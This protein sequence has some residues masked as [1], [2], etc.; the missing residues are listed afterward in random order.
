MSNNKTETQVVEINQQFAT[1][2]AAGLSSFPKRLPAKYFY[3]EKGDAIFQQIMG[4]E[5]Y[6]PTRC[7]YE[8]FER[9]KKQLLELFQNT[10]KPFKLL[11]FGAGDGHKTK[12]LLDLFTTQKAVFQYVPIDISAN[13]LEVL[14]ADLISCF[15]NLDIR[16]FNGD[17]FEALESL[18]G[19]TSY[20]KVVIFLGGN[21][22]NFEAAEAILFLKEIE[23]RLSKDDLIMVGIDLKKNPQTI[24]DA[25]YDKKGVTSAFNYN[26]LTR[27]NNELDGNFELD[28]FLHFPTY[29][30]LTGDTK[31]FLVAKK[32]HGV[33]LKAIDQSF[34]FE[35]WEAIDM[36]ISKKYGL[37][38]VSNLAKQ[39]G[40][41]LVEHFFDS[42]KFFVDTV[43]RKK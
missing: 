39:A 9:H 31:S 29:N 11:E 22:G 24:L 30:P 12:V 15:P 26:L 42:K 18:D 7:E 4:L 43:W 19:D 34:E 25:Y 36:E 41:E 20:R 27:I 2:I 37:K 23:K 17:Y 8:I 35:A 32:T 28:N 21:I 40:F 5:E 10:G 6:Y 33:Q 1:D 16:P 3:D 14:E 13:I 38:G